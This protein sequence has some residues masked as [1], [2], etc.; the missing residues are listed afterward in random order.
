MRTYADLVRIA[1]DIEEEERSRWDPKER[2]RV[3]DTEAS[4]GRT[5]WEA[6]ARKENAAIRAFNAEGERKLCEFCA[7]TIRMALA[8]GEL[9]QASSPEDLSGLSPEAAKAGFDS[10][11]A[12]IPDDIWFED[13]Y[14]RK[15]ASWST[16]DGG[17]PCFLIKERDTE[18]TEHSFVCAARRFPGSMSYDAWE[19]HRLTRAG[20]HTRSYTGTDYEFHHG[21]WAWDEDTEEEKE[22]KDRIG[23][24]ELANK[25]RGA[26]RNPS[27]EWHEGKPYFSNMLSRG[28]RQCSLKSTGEMQVN[29]VDEG[30]V[31]GRSWE[32]GQIGFR[33]DGIIFTGEEVARMSGTHEG[34]NLQYRF[35]DPSG[36]PLKAGEYLMPVRI[37]EKE[38][39]TEVSE[40]LNLFAA[41]GRFISEH[42]RESF[43]ILFEK[44]VLEKLKFYYRS[45]PAGYGKL[46]GMQVIKRLM[47]V[48]GTEKQAEQVR[49]VI[50]D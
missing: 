30:I 14:G 19:V 15:Y 35:A 33:I 23:F 43:G 48:E 8:D 40:L 44:M 49:R 39:V 18:G 27:L 10:C 32:G 41:D 2:E 29:Y 21:R 17:G 36:Q 47:W 50:Q 42:D 31:Q 16:G 45:R 7:Q 37:G 22:R 11:F 5:W 46:A 13:R 20:K 26:L 4:F 25:I 28:G 1:E 38:L 3:E 24:L 9:P 12:R 6:A 34:W